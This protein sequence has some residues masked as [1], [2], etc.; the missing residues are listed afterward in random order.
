MKHSREWLRS[1][2]TSSCHCSLL[3]SQRRRHWKK[4]RQ[5]GGEKHFHRL[6]IDLPKS[7]RA[8]RDFK[9]LQKMR[10]S[11]SVVVPWP[12]LL[13]K[14]PVRKVFSVV[15]ATSSPNS[16]SFDRLACS[17][18][19]CQDITVETASLACSFEEA[20]NPAER[21]ILSLPMIIQA[22]LTLVWQS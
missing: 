18:F 20:A 8:S 4:Y 1:S 7:N 2:C 13:S 21:V 10:S 14:Q 9:E 12:S 15:K 22:N 19:L 6:R 5:S 16:R 11:A 17:F 3:L